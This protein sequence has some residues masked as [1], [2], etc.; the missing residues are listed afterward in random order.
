MKYTSPEGKV[1]DINPRFGHAL[2][3]LGWTTDDTAV[4]KQDP[5]HGDSTG[6]D[7]DRS[8]WKKAD[9]ALHAETIGID[10]DGLTVD[11]LKEAV[12]TAEDTATGAEDPTD[13]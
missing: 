13:E 11:E 2:E 3:A 4:E 1:A 10:S 9:W 8:K 6:G 7:T 12:A 5:D